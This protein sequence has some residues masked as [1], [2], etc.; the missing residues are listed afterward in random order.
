[1]TTTT[2]PRRVRQSRLPGA[3][4]GSARSVVRPHRF[5]NP[6]KLGR[7][8]TRAEVVA[9]FEADLLAGRL[10]FSVQDVRRELRGRDLA[11]WCPLDQACHAGVLL[12]IANQGATA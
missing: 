9:R 3:S 2:I 8:G 6:H 1:M 7:D 10:D 4:I 11:C 12:T 5:S